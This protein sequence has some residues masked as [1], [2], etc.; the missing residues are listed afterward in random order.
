MFIVYVLILAFELVYFHQL[1]RHQRPANASTTEQTTLF[2]VRR[3]IGSG[4][5]RLPASVVICQQ[6]S[7]GYKA[8]F[9]L[10]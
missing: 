10:S 1:N 7:T 2:D 6:S 4:P 5:C 9:R 8:R 3:R